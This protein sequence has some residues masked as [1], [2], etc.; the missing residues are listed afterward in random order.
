MKKSLIITFILLIIATLLDKQ[1][2]NIITQNRITLL[3][4]IFIWISTLSSGIAIFFIITILL[5]WE[6]NKRNYIPLMWITLIIALSITGLLKIL[7]ARPR[8]YINTL[9]N[10]NSYSFPSGH[11]TAV[12]A[13]LA[14]IN[15]TFPKIKYFW[16]IFA[17][18]VLFTRVYLGIHY[19]TD[20]IAGALIGHTIGLLIL[21]KQNFIKNKIFKPI[22]GVIKS[23]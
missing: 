11:T 16:F 15:K 5:L 4:P 18:L 20:V 10:K 9:I 6:K 22:R 8:P 13:T 3:N 14:I 12:F 17:F 2:L 7:I 19:P 1:I 23:H 21:Q